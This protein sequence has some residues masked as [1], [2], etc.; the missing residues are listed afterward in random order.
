MV[1]FYKPVKKEVD[2]TAFEVTC[3]GLDLLGRGIARAQN[4]V[5]FIKGLM[6]GENARISPLSQKGR[7]GEA[8]MTKLITP[9]AQR[10]RPDCPY[11]E[12][13]GGCQLQH[14]PPAM[15]LEAK[16]LG[17]EHLIETSCNLKL[18]PISFNV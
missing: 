15:A 7:T 4:T 10:R 13:C 5:W 6:P 8:R 18:P 3:T 9:S 17:F 2:K 12:Q 14:L 11:Q 16:V 1:S